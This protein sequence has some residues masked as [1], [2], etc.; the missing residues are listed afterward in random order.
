VVPPV[1]RRVMDRRVVGFY[2]GDVTRANLHPRTRGRL[3]ARWGGPQE[4]A[5]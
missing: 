1:W 2:D 5:A 4:G 3:L